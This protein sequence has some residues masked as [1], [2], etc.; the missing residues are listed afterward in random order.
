[1]QL[2][3][4]AQGWVVSDDGQGVMLVL[5]WKKQGTWHS[6]TQRKQLKPAGSRLRSRRLAAA[7]CLVQQGSAGV[8]GEEVLGKPL[9]GCV[10]SS[11]CPSALS[12]S[13][14]RTSA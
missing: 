2:A 10:L 12:Q 14:C 3:V 11:S 6:C 13:T 5:V 4:E 1:M 9:K 8:K 7:A